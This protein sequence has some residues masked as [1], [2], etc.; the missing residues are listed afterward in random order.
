MGWGIPV[1]IGLEQARLALASS[2]QR[3][4]AA[5][6][7]LTA[8]VLP[9]ALPVAQHKVHLIRV[10]WHLERHGLPPALPGQV[11]DQ[12]GEGGVVAGGHLHITRLY[13]EL[14]L[15]HRTC[16]NITGIVPLSFSLTLM[17]TLIVK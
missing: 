3:C 8:A 12:A 10:G 9:G 13:R 4:A 7:P 16:N 17:G 14:L 15:A 1:A 2:S 5:A 11:V 6:G